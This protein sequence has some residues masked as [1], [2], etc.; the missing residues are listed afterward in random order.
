MNIERFF[1]KTVLHS[2]FQYLFFF[3]EGQTLAAIFT[4]ASLVVKKGL[5]PYLFV[6]WLAQQLVFFWMIKDFVVALNHRITCLNFFFFGLKYKK[7][8]KKK[9]KYL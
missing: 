2:A 6:C 5:I 3:S 9:S 4:A 7:K 1:L 8:K